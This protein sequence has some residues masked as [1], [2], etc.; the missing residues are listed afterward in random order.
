MGEWVSFRQPNCHL[1]TSP[2]HNLM[3]LESTMPGLHFTADRI[4][5]S[6]F[7]FQWLA[8]KYMCVM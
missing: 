1:T 3:L 7:K 4:G 6:L 2:L 5:L 8:P